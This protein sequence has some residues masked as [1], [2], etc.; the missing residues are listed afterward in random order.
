[1]QYAL[2]RVEDDLVVQ[3]RAPAVR[4]Q[5]RPPVSSGG[6]H[7][8]DK[9]MLEVVSLRMELKKTGEKLSHKAKKVKVGPG[10]APARAPA[11]ALAR[12]PLGRPAVLRGAA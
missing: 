9:A 11:R 8:Q 5:W 4:L 6:V 7:A 10:P 1:V 3:H 12:A 2:R